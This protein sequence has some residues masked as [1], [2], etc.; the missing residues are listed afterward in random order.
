VSYLDGG[1]ISE[2]QGKL[3]RDEKSLKRI[4][5]SK[6]GS[7]HK[8]SVPHDMVDDLLLEGWE[9]D[10]DPLKY[11]TKLR[12]P[13]KHS[14]HFEDRVWCQMYDLG[15]RVLNSDENFHLPYGKNDGET[16]QIDVIAISEEVVLI[17]E[18]KSKKIRGKSSSIKSDAEGLRQKLDGFRKS[19]AALLDG[20]KRKLKYIYATNNIRID[21]ESIDADRLEKAGAFLYTNTTYDYIQGLIKSYKDAAHYQFHAMLFSGTTISKDRIEVP[22]IKGNMGGEPYYM[23]SIEPQTL[24]KLAYVLHRTQANE[25]ELPTY[26]R[27]LVPSRLKGISKFIDQGGFFP[28]SLLI[29]FSAKGNKLEFTPNSKTKSSNAQHGILKIPNAYAIAYIIDGQHRLYGYALS[30]YKETNTVPVVAFLNLEPDVQLKLFM[31]INENQKAVSPTLR[32][33]LEEDLFWNADRLDS[34]MKALRSSV[35]RK[36]ATDESS[37]LFSKV[38][39]GEDKSKLSS[40]PFARALSRSELIP[41]AYQTKFADGAAARSLYNANETKHQR[42]MERARKRIYELIAKTYDI[43]LD[44]LDTRASEKLLL[45]NRGTYSLVA[46]LGSLNA[47]LTDTEK[48]KCTTKSDERI[49][50]IQPYLSSLFKALNTLSDDEFSELTTKLGQ[51]AETLWLRKFQSFINAA[52]SDY[53]PIELTDWKERQDKE[54]QEDA[55]K[56]GTEIERH[57]KATVINQLKTLYGSDWELEIAPIK[58]ECDKRVSEQQEKDYKDGLPKKDIH[59]TEQFYITDYKKILEKYWTKNSD[60]EG[61]SPFQNDF[62]IDLGLGE[63]NSKSEKLKWLSMFN[64]WRNSWA[65]EGTKEKGLNRSEVDMVKQIHKHLFN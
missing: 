44:E 16:Q 32:I 56:L 15:F 57:I 14:Q 26:Q 58:R 31:D 8:Q 20:N 52:H 41:K 4:Y 54:L 62:A 24:L 49:K 2:L 3:S 65:H 64:S 27:L 7:F 63:F 33:T 45:S 39:I 1:T 28:N 30:S 25:A 17:I 6:K 18:C 35:I 60:T 40:Q 10:G 51:G 13:K 61:F 48:L 12:K 37:P 5:N 43:A 23:F 21:R 19:L 50:V 9:Q 59:W 22:A 34:R 55:R 38:S 47:Y 46:L 53:S 36:L 11:K 29:N 42:E